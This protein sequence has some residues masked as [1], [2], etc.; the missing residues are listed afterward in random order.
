[1]NDYNP[2]K[3][4]VSFAGVM[5]TGFMDGSMVEVEHD[6]DAYKKKTGTQGDVTRVLSCNTGGRVTVNLLTGS[7]SNMLLSALALVDRRTGA[8][9][10][11]ILIKD[12]NGTT[13]CFAESAWIMKMPKVDYSDDETGRTWV[14]DCADMEI[15]VGSTL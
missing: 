11:P 6:E 10:G 9:K 5:I 8:G 14:F 1:M 3:V 12:L 13:V 4:S 15:V 7:P 2:R